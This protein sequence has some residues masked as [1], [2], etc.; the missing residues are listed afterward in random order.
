MT[1]TWGLKYWEEHY[2]IVTDVSKTI[3]ERRAYFM[4]IMLD[5][6]PMTPKRIE[7]IVS[8]I[9]GLECKVTENVAPNTFRVTMYGGYPKDLKGLC[10][11]LDSRVPAHLLYIIKAIETIESTSDTYPF[12]IGEF[13]ER[14]GEV[15]VADYTREKERIEATTAYLFQGIAVGNIA[16]KMGEIEVIN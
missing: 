9:T 15:K 8:G 4:S 7:T 13:A 2:G 10:E 11:L 6:P 14:L 1:A 12:V 16:E 3:E 5:K